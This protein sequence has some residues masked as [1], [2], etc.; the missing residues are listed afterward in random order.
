[1]RQRTLNCDPNMQG[2]YG[3]SEMRKF[4]AKIPD[5]SFLLYQA[6]ESI[7]KYKLSTPNKDTIRNKLNK[8]VK[9]KILI[10]NGRD[11]PIYEKTG[12]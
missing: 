4:L 2:Y 8:A 1:M 7:S 12:K 6:V 10:K 5:E 9:I 11:D 3:A